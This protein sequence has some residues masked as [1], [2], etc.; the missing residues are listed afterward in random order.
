MADQAS[1]TINIDAKVYKYR[2]ESVSGIQLKD[3]KAAL[4]GNRD[5]H[6]VSDSVFGN[7]ISGK[8]SILADVAQIR[9]SGLW[10]L[11]PVLL[12][13]IPSTMTTPNA[14][15]RLDI[16]TKNVGIL[17]SMINLFKEFLL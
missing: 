12:S 6:I 11:N 17:N 5:H 16:P 13:C 7:F 9:I 8:T 14:T 15:L 4:V 1:S 2:P 3:D 10:T